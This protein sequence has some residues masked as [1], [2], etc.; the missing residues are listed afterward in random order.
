MAIVLHDKRPFA[1][2]VSF[3]FA[4]LSK[5]V[6]QL[7]QHHDTFSNAMQS[8]VAFS[9]A[10]Q[11]VQVAS[12]DVPS[13]RSSA[14]SATS[15]LPLTVEGPCVSKASLPQTPASC[16]KMPEVQQDLSPRTFEFFSHTQLK[17][18]QTEEA[19]KI[20]KLANENDILPQALI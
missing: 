9:Q 3:F 17:A 16:S 11:K 14:S 1:Y 2:V 6:R 18:E 15:D 8:L 7:V 10:Q 20:Y 4:G 19:G 5:W 13:P 12:V